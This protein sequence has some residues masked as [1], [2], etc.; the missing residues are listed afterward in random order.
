MN[1]K[2]QLYLQA[3]L[4]GEL[5]SPDA[6]RVES[7]LQKDPEL[8]A[9]AHELRQIRS[10]LQIDESTIKVPA[11]REFYWSQIERR[12]QS[13]EADAKPPGAWARFMHHWWWK[14]VAPA[15][16]AAL[17]AVSLL[18]GWLPHRKNLTLNGF[19]IETN[20]EANVVAFQSDQDGITV[21]WV[22]MQ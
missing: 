7:W 3:W 9:L 1:K 11:S 4:D 2:R 21:V 20:P 14:W 10:S 18:P 22:D 6:Q 16:A 15:A 12:L 13:A 17:L 8:Q 5:P 19:E